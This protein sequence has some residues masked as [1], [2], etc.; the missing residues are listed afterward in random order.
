M[1]LLYVDSSCDLNA[2]EIKKLGVECI[3]LPYML[4]NVVCQYDG[5]IDYSEFY[6][7]FKKGICVS[8][9]DLDDDF[10]ISAFDEGMKQ[11]NDIIYIKSSENILDSSAICHIREMLIEKYPSNRFEIIDSK[12]FSIGYGLLVY[13]LAIKYRNGSTVDEILE[14]ADR[15]KDEYALYFSVDSCEQLYN[16]NLIDSS[17]FSG[18]MLNIKPIF[19]IDID[20]KIQLI[21]KVSGRKKVTLKLLELIRQM[22][23]NVVDYPIGIV[24]IDNETE[25]N[26]LKDKLI[27]LYGDANIIVNP[28]SPSTSA[29]LGLKSLGLAF[30]IHKK[31]H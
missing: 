3:Y 8:R 29:I 12:N 18:T 19:G 17:C 26:I 7:R 22:G 11:G 25:A 13:S 2:G 23:E 6:S 4:N 16:H 1:S 27:E 28:A 24:H 14:L 15:L 31:M 10:Y 5:N 21:D 20:G 9:C 30:H